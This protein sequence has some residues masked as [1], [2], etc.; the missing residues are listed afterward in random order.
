MDFRRVRLYRFV[1]VIMAVLLLAFLVRIA[2]I[3]HFGAVNSRETTADPDSFSVY[4]SWITVAAIANVT[5]F[6]E[7]RLE[8]IQFIADSIWTSVILLVRAL[9]GVLR[10]RRTGISLSKRLVPSGHISGMH[11]LKHD[12]FRRRV[13]TGTTQASSPLFSSVSY[14]SSFSR[15]N[16]LSA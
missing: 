8:R 15:K 2:D 5:V 7:Y 4:F 12:V 10:M 9:I 3:L 6:R 14:R 13:S 1:G 11:M 16:F